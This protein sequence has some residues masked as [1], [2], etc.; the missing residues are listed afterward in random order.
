MRIFSAIT[1]LKNYVAIGA[2]AVNAYAQSPP[3]EEPTYVRVDQQY[4]DWYKARFG[5][6]LDPK[7]HVLPVKHA[8]QGHPESGAL[9]AK[10]IETHLV[11]LDF[12]STTHEPCLYR[13]IFEG[14]EI[15]ACRQIDDFMFSGEHESV[16]CRLID[17]LGAEVRLEAEDGFVSH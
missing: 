5:I 15:F 13:G 2:D 16:V 10:K 12:K 1:A 6:Q 9:W 3:P 7:I 14:H 17:K 4:A 11:D 8:L